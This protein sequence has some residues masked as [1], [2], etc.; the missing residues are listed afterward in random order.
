MI[1]ANACEGNHPSVSL[2]L[3]DR[4]GLY[5]AI[6]TDPTSDGPSP[7]ISSWKAAYGFLE[8]GS[9]GDEFA[10][11]IYSRLVQGSE[12]ALSAWT[13]AAF[14]PWDGVENPNLDREKP[15]TRNVPLI[16]RAAR[17]GIKASNKVSDMIT[18]AHAHKEEILKLKQLACSQDAYQAGRD[19][20]GMAI[21]RWGDRG[22]R[23]RLL[24]V[25]AILVDAMAKLKTWPVQQD[26]GCRFFSHG[27]ITDHLP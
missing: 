5:H 26:G 9:R 1:V 15:R 27:D 20:F 11:P 17:E 7:D 23:W 21:R 24:I 13:L 25:Y 16:T 4:L 3:V 22:D 2:E 19:V 18:A 6:F 12:D 14:A 10:G 8:A